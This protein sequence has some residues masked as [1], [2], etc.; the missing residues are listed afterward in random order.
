MRCELDLY[1]NLSNVNGQGLFLSVD[2]NGF[3]QIEQLVVL[4]VFPP[5]FLGQPFHRDIIG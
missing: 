3:A 2:L 1:I 4:F 5:L